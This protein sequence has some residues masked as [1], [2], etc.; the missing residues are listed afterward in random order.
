MTGA[1][2]L[3]LRQAF[4]LKRNVFA[5]ALNVNTATIDRWENGTSKPKGLAT[6]VLQALQSVAERAPDARLLGGQLS[7]GIGALVAAALDESRQRAESSIAPA[8]GVLWNK[9]VSR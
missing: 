5:R 3:A 8:S 2:I 4:G 6:V 1:D 9:V 7:L